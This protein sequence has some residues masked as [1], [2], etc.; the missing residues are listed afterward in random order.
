[1]Q[2]AENTTVRTK[3]I[4]PFG[5]HVGSLIKQHIEENTS[6]TKTYVAKELG[7]TRTCF[8]SRLSSNFYGNIHDLVKVSLFLKADFIT[9]ALM[10]LKSGGTQPKIL[11]TEQEFNNMKLQLAHAEKNLFEKE[12][13]L[14]LTHE[15]I[16]KYK[17]MK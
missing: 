15:L 3:D 1:M 10:V 2:R 6:Y 12:R 16:E 9:P 8:T 13:E 17:M 5:L 4:A 14:N 11:Y 7:L